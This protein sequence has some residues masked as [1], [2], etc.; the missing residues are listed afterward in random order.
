MKLSEMLAALK[1]QRDEA[2]SKMTSLHTKAADEGRTFDDAEQA[3]F[4]DLE[5]RIEKLEKQIASTEAMERLTARSAVTVTQEP[6]PQQQGQSQGMMIPQQ[7][8]TGQQRFQVVRQ[9]PKGTA[10]TRYAMALAA[11]RGNLIQAEQIAK[12]HFGDTTPEV[13]TV[14]KAA[15]AAGTTQ[16]ATWAKPLVEYQNM[17]SEFI[18]LL[19]PET[20]IGEIDGFRRVPFNIKMPRQTSGASAGWVGE[21]AP[22]P[23]SKL[24]FDNITMPWAKIAVIIAITEELAR[25]SDPSA[26][27]LVRTDMIA[28]IAEFM[29]Q[30]FI[31]P[32]VTALQGIRPASITNG[33]PNSASSGTDFDAAMTDIGKALTA[34]ATAQI[35]GPYVWV[36]NPRTKIA[37]SLMRTSQDVFA[38]PSIAAN[39]TLMGYPI[40]DSQQVGIT[41]TAPGT[42]F[43]VLMAP[44]QIFLADD[45][46]VTLDVSREASVQMDSAPTAGASALV[47]LWQ[48][49]LIGLRAERFC[50][51]MPRRAAAV[52]V[53]TGVAY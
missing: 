30:Q 42:T 37:L 43:I 26:E 53:I 25:F 15:V 2:I 16:D 9:L 10:F 45:G 3:A 7:T 4:E 50:Y 35:P 22:K 48:N 1:K 17:A 41:G 14:L 40:V 12:T 31:D 38:F 49:N 27:A 34:M 11:S 21:G 47:S 51:W 44:G 23:V 19:R 29:N 24:G 39:N 8:H 33:A 18:E 20:I 36:M 32:T 28:A 13:V 6:T 5:E 46:Q 52:Y